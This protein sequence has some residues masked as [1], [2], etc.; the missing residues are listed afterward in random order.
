MRANFAVGG[1]SVGRCEHASIWKNIVG[2]GTVTALH[3]NDFQ[4]LEA[5]ASLTVE[6]LGAASVVARAPAAIAGLVV[7]LD[8]YRKKSIELTRVHATFLIELKSNGPLSMKELTKRPGL[9]HLN[10]RE[11]A[12]ELQR[13]TRIRRLDGVRTSLVESDGEDR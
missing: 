8:K 4:L 5:A 1:H 6:Y 13:L 7:L 9:E 2:H 12:S 11:T 3:N 10:E